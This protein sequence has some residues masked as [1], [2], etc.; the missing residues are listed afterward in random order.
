MDLACRFLF[1][2]LACFI[3]ASP[4]HAQTLRIGEVASIQGSAS[5]SVGPRVRL[6]DG[7]PVHQNE[8]IQ[9]SAES[10]TSLAFND[11][12]HLSIGPS[13]SVRLDRFVYE[14]NGTTRS[15]IVNVS[16]GIMR[17]GTGN[18]DPSRFQLR[19]PLATIG[20][21]GT[22]LAI[23]VEARREVVALESGL[24]V[25]TVGSNSVTLR[26]GE[27][28]VMT[29][30]GIEGPQAGGT[31]GFRYDRDCGALRA[32]YVSYVLPRYGS[33]LDHSGGGSGGRDPG[34]GG[35]SSGGPS[36]S[37]SDI[38]LKTD[39]RRIGMT[40]DGVPLYRFRYKADPDRVFTGV[41]AQDLLSSRPDVLSIGE[42]G[43]Y[44][45]DY[46][47][48]GLTSPLPSMR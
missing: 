40:Q 39:I 4:V 26:P 30:R 36:T 1:L 41:M 11:S 33:S 48:L 29:P 45:V 3:G 21:R 31:S 17:F 28:V 19:T 8:T 22:V 42:D 24:A 18:S 7:A 37:G 38:R 23:K 15:A 2:W 43:F 25:V 12:T 35:S 44:R 9:T 46:A 13:S 5:G 20:I 6:E 32:C 34:G 27:E 47:R 10:A 14:G 16:R